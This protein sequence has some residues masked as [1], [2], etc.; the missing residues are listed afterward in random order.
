MADLWS[1]AG[2]GRRPPCGQG[3]GV[4]RLPDVRGNRLLRQRDGTAACRLRPREGRGVG[5]L[6]RRDAARRWATGN[7]PAPPRAPQADASGR[8]RTAKAESFSGRQ[9]KGGERDTQRTPRRAAIEDV[10]VLV[11]PW[12]RQARTGE[13]GGFYLKPSKKLWISM[14]K[15]VSFFLRSSTFRME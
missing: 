15:S 1:A 14:L 4:W 5:A 11:Q 8:E 6:V 13:T 7:L 2:R 3:R 10:Q 12:Q 9:A